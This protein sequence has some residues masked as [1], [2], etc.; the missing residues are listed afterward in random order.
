MCCSL[1]PNP[2]W[3]LPWDVGF[4][5]VVQ[6][7]SCKN[8]T[9]A[10]KSTMTMTLVHHRSLLTNRN[11]C[12]ETLENNITTAPVWLWIYRLTVNK[13]GRT[14]KNCGRQTRLHMT[15]NL[16][17]NNTVA[18]LRCAILG[19]KRRALWI[20]KHFGFVL[21]VATRENLFLQVMIQQSSAGTIIIF[22]EPSV[23]CGVGDFTQV[24]MGELSAGES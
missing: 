15:I 12:R 3:S 16:S 9:L 19:S 23:P 8:T 5:Y 20:F 21:K 6:L 18:M 17:Y 1:F 13:I 2:L 22:R 10:V 4:R 24:E 7:S 11:K 14:G